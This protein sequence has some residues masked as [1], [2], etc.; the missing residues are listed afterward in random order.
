MGD[1]TEAKVRKLPKAIVGATRYA[2]EQGRLKGLWI[3]QRS[4]SSDV[5]I[6]VKVNAKLALYY[7]QLTGSIYG[8]TVERVALHFL[9]DAIIERC[10][11]STRHKKFTDAFLQSFPRMTEREALVELLR[12]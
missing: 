5:V 3:S 12:D 4:R 6:G 2:R 8:D 7:K 11:A 10:K 9:R 1:L